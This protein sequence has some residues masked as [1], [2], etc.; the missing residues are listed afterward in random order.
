MKRY[1]A[2]L[3]LSSNFTKSQDLRKIQENACKLIVEE[4]TPVTDCTRC[5]VSTPLMR[6]IPRLCKECGSLANRNWQ[7]VDSPMLLVPKLLRNGYVGKYN[8]A[9][10]KT[11]DR[12][13]N[14]IFGPG[15]I[16]VACERCTCW[17]CRAMAF[18]LLWISEKEILRR[19][20]RFQASFEGRGGF[21]PLFQERECVPPTTLTTLTRGEEH[22]TFQRNPV[23]FGNACIA[24]IA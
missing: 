9:L 2:S 8:F 4:S 14:L 21:V 7:P 6:E 17:P 12:E 10:D 13:G 24:R 16:R 23:I 22:E 3:L 19:Q 15:E 11:I 20:R 5:I 1:D 18:R